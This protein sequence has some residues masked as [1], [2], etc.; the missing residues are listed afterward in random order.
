[1]SGG[2]CGDAEA[3]A[4]VYH[5]LAMSET[6]TIGLVQHVCA[7]DPAQNVARTLA[8]IREAA[9]RGAHVVCTQELFR[10]RYFCQSEEHAN[11]DLAEPIPGPTTEALSRVAVECGVVVVASL[12]ERRGPGVFHNT[13]VVFE[14]DGSIA[15]RY[16]KMHVPDDP[17]YY[18]KFYFAPGDLGFQA[19][20]TSAGRLGTLVCWDQWFPE[21]ARIT[22]LM[23]A[24]VLFYPT[25]IGWHPGEKEQY[26]EAQRNAWETVMRSH[27]IAN[28]VYVVAVNR[29]GFEAAPAGAT[30][31]LQGTGTPSGAGGIE[32]WGGSFVC[33]PD[34]EVLVSGGDTD[35]VLLAEIDFGKVEEARLHWPFLRDRRTDAYGPITERWLGES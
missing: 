15:G 32:F 10:T 7:S 18:E 14:R 24:E 5:S 33:A 34:G 19:F 25:A 1:M 30:F 6:I 2:Y 29:T 28:G 26:G 23:G 20:D 16:R 4:S 8:G 3:F 22:T 13:V 9:S 21:A 31:S 17:L 11:F 35:A 12:F 27:A